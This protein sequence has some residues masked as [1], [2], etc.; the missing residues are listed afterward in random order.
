MRNKDKKMSFQKMMSTRDAFG[1]EL[2]E[3]GRKHKEIVVLDADLSKATKTCWFA[4][5]F[6]NRFFDM[7]ISEQDMLGTAA[8]LSLCGKIPIASTFTVF[9]T[10]KAF[11]Q[12]R[13][14]IAYPGL[15]VKIVATHGGITI[16]ADGASHQPIE[17]IALMRAIPNMT[18]IVPADGVE[19]KEALKYAIEIKGPVFMVV[20]RDPTPIIFSDDHRF[21]F[22]H[23]E[24][25]RE[26]KDVAIIATGIMVEKALRA[27]EKLGE[28]GINACIVNMHTIKPI[29]WELIVEVSCKTGGIVTAE[30]HTIIGG[31]GSAVAEVISENRPV[32][33][34]RIGLRD[35]FGQSGSAEELLREYHLTEEDIIKAAEEVMRK[36]YKRSS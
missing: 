5:E 27:G 36:K 14:T 12:I 15:N 34:K 22:S 4:K 17:Y 10:T 1:E 20:G 18:I 2:V 13:N 30:E 35:R 8:G 23:G 29:D 28:R 24:V 16:G 6:P 19:T 26:G 9:A 33:L 11:D 7:G 31:L 25:L 32:S 21:D 3:L